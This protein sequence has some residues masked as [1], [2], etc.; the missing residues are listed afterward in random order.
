[1]REAGPAAIREK[2][3]RQTARLVELADERGFALHAPRDPKRR[4][5]TVAFAVPHGYEVSQELLARDIIVD[6]RPGG[7]IRVAPHFY[8]RDVELA[9]AGAAI[10]DILATGAWTR[11]QGRRSVVT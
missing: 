4:G 9:A 3:R 5:G 1:V 2:S 6:Y 7:G 11:H 10:D 8:T